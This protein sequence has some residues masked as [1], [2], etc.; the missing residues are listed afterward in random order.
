MEAIK[1]GPDQD[2]LQGYAAA[3]S[4]AGKVR[5][6][7]AERFPI[8]PKGYSGLVPQLLAV[9]LH[10]SNY[11]EVW[12][13]MGELWRIMVELWGN[14]GELWGIIRELYGIMVKL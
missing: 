2:F 8:I 13:T 14:V 7:A 10:W 3:K 9:P 6:A 5:L 1:I 12:R 4:L 11:G